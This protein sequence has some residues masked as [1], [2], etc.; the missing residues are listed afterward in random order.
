MSNQKSNIELNQRWTEVQVNWHEIKHEIDTAP[1]GTK[2]KVKQDIAQR[3]G[4]SKDQIHSALRTQFGKAK[5]VKRDD[6]EQTEEYESNR[7]V[8]YLVAEQ[9]EKMKNAGSGERELSTERILK[10]LVKWG[11]EEAEDCTV[12]TINRIIREEFGYRQT[13]PR[14]RLECTH[15]L[16]QVQVD[17]SF[18]KYFSIAGVDPVTGDW[19]M[20]ASKKRL[21]YKEGDKKRRAMLGVIIDS[22]SRLRYHHCVVTSGESSN[23]TIAILNQFFN[24][25]EDELAFRHVGWNWHM[26]NGPLAKS[27]EGKSFFK[28]IDRPVTTSTPYEKTGIGKAERSWPLIWQLEMELVSEIGVGGIISLEQYNAALLA[29]CVRQQYE[30]HP[31]YAG[32]R[33]ID[34]YQQS[35]LRQDPRPETIEADLSKLVYTFLERTVGSD[36]KIMIG[37]KAYEVPV[38]AG[39]H[40]TTE[41]RIRVMINR[42][43]QMKGEL[44]DRNAPQFEIREFDPTMTGSYSGTHQKTFAQ[45]LAKDIKEKNSMTEQIREQAKGGTP[46]AAPA[47]PRPLMPASKPAAIHSPFASD[48][49]KH[50]ELNTQN[51]DKCI[52]KF[53][54]I[55]FVS[56]IMKRNGIEFNDQLYEF[57]DDYVVQVGLDKFEI[58]KA[59]K[60]II[61]DL[62]GTNNTG[63]V[64]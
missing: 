41:R 56:E 22:Y 8:A 17:F 3:L 34:L 43:G 30:E 44:I 39:D 23:S 52:S 18:S 61:D 57:F 46:Q 37:K 31:F 54:A 62:K 60:S 16:Q 53:E 1:H 2:G 9:K 4:L 48:E 35:I 12:S 38:W 10:L 27:Q 7:R 42:D 19:L 26:D 33:R 13:T 49:T 51:S 32:Q 50:S 21:D 6:L 63:T 28:A 15:A 36:Q 14:K 11:I 24:R 45:R 55:T 20:Q 59:A 5:I 64:G 25:D 58:Q 47:R 29:E 40:Y